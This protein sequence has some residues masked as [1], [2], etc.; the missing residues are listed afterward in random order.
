MPNLRQSLSI[1]AAFIITVGTIVGMFYEVDTHYAKADDVSIVVEEMQADIQ[2]VS[3]RVDVMRLEDELI[4]DKKKIL[5]L[6]DRW[7][8]VFY[9]RFDRYWQTIEELKGVMPDYYKEEYQEA[10]DKKEKLEKQIEEKN[11]KKGES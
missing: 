7:G 2:Y 9:E 8:D 3:S 11:K 4:I 5:R 6:E 1:V 10:L